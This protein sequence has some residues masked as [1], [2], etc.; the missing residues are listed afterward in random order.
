MKKIDA[1]YTNFNSQERFDLAL[2]ALA[3]GDQSEF[4]KLNSTCP[5]KTYSCVDAQFSERIECLKRIA[6]VFLAHCNAELKAFYAYAKMYILLQQ[7]RGANN[8]A[9][10]E[11]IAENKVMINQCVISVQSAREALRVFFLETGMSH[12]HFFAWILQWW[13]IKR[14]ALDVLDQLFS[15]MCL[16]FDFEIIQELKAG[17]FNLWPKTL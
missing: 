17:F 11:V 9:L 5:W 8:E 7:L 4:E 3:R 2:A 14:E 12:D 16:S 1:L 15:E 6:I 13:H 10:E